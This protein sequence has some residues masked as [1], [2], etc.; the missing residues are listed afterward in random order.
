MHCHTL[1]VLLCLSKEVSL[2][3]MRAGDMKCLLPNFLNA[4]VTQLFLSNVL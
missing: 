1:P 2:Q 3:G 4:I